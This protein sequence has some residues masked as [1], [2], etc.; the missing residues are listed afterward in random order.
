[1][2]NNKGKTDSGIRFYNSLLFRTGLITLTALIFAVFMGALHTYYLAMKEEK[3]KV[4]K[5]AGDISGVMTSWCQPDTLEWMLD[6]WQEHGDELLILPPGAEVDTEKIDEYS[7]SH[8]EA[9]DL[10][11]SRG[12]LFTPEELNAMDEEEIKKLAEVWYNNWNS[13]FRIL[14]ERDNMASAGVFFLEDGTAKAVFLNTQNASEPVV[15]GD[16]IPF[17]LDMH[18]VVKKVLETGSPQNDAEHIVSTVDGSEYLY[19]VYPI[20]LNGKIRCLT[21][22]TFFWGDVKDRLTDEMWKIGRRILFYMLFAVILLLVLLNVRMLRPIK[23]LQNQ[24]RDY[25]REKDS[26]KVR[27][28]LERT[29]TRKDEL[30]ALSRDISLLTVE[31]DD[32]LKEIYTYSKEKAELSAELS[33]ATRIQA[34]ALPGKFPDRK[35]FDLYAYMTPALDVGGDFYDFYMIDEDH[36]ALIIADVSDKGV[37]AAL[38]M[39]LTQTMLETL[40]MT[41]GKGLHPKEIFATV[42]ERLREKNS[43]GMFVT[44]WMGILTISTGELL[45]SN[46]G[47]VYPAICPGEGSDAGKFILH[48]ARHSPPLAAY[49]GIPFSSEDLHLNKGDILFVYTDGVTEATSPS[50]EL[51]GTERMVSVLD[52]NSGKTSRE[53]IEKMYESLLDFMGDNEQFDDITMLC[54]RYFG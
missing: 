22:C 4:L 36:L 28:A 40:S 43:I 46:A 7:A 45:C 14:C 17:N 50:V 23:G 37:P 38:F 44:A 11:L 26:E 25:S 3:Q 13:L 27:S 32:Y 19:A 8:K 16:V 30:G 54:I 35:E 24:I 41:S 53:I 29:D 52:E 49:Q 31:I 51:F 15:P 39:M 2:T 10:F 9:I 18:P 1:M 6:Y 47:H 21:Q 34:N 20:I 33:L 5:S 42:N 48:K 12:N